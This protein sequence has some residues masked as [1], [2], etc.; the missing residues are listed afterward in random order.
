MVEIGLTYMHAWLLLQQLGAAEAH[1]LCGI[2]VF[3]SFDCCYMPIR[4][5][6]AADRFIPTCLRQ[7][8]AVQ[9]SL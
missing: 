2:M 6:Q 5:W 7:V 4:V 1:S 8:L 9:A 3:A